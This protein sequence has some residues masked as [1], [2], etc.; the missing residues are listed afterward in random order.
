MA[1]TKT[2]TTVT[3]IPDIS[4][5]VKNDLTASGTRAYIDG[6]LLLKSDTSHTHPT[7][8]PLASPALTGTPTAPAP[9]AGDNSTRLATT[10]WVRSYGGST[11]LPLT[12]GLLSGPL[13]LNADPSGNMHAATKQYVDNSVAV[14]GTRVVVA[15]T[16]G[17]TTL[18]LLIPTAGTWLVR[19]DYRCHQGSFPVSTLYVDGYIVD[20]TP[21]LGDPSGTSERHFWGMR[22]ITTTG[23]YVVTASMVGSGEYGDLNYRKFTM[24]ATNIVVT[25]I[26]GDRGYTAGGT[27]IA[28]VRTDNIE[29]ML[30]DSETVTS[31]SAKLSSVKGN[32]AGVNSSE[33]GYFGG[34]SDNPTMYGVIDGLRFD[35]EA[36]VVTGASLT[37]ARQELTGVNSAIRGYFAGGNTSILSTIATNEIDGLRFDTE[38][39]INPTAVL[40]LARLSITGINSNTRGYF[41]GGYNSTSSTPSTEID[42]ILFSTETSYNPTTSLPIALYDMGGVNSTI[43][44]YLAGGDNGTNP[45][46]PMYVFNFSTDSLASLVATLSVA[47][48]SVSSINSTIRGYF[49]GGL[50]S[51]TTNI[52][53]EIDGIRFDTE[54]LINPGSAL[55]IA[56]EDGA[57][58][59]TSGIL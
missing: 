32:I 55:M 45:V 35:T 36:N 27:T 26:E 58:V 16:T 57:G 10:S 21:N 52:S 30:F 13:T 34:G 19:A 23:P 24:V 59:Q 4:A 8:A 1:I 47:R 29:G 40:S 43:K 56:R 25:P 11:F 15:E 39:V 3:D 44:G 2:N 5:S 46:N 7:Y 28:L 37:I 50:L 9:S 33:R 41:V 54:T 48:W 22:T 51:G 42:G 20:Y 6:Q 38:S 17:L 14:S 53:S 31:S 12:G 18:N 49:L